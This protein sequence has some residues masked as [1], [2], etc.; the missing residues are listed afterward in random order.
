[1][2]AWPLFYLWALLYMS[3]LTTGVG[4]LRL[5]LAWELTVD[6]DKMDN[7]WNLV[8]MIS[9]HQRKPPNPEIGN[10][11]KYKHTAGDLGRKP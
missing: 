4:M 1:M 2:L 5:D 11:W 8:Y 3:H 6:F 10:V 9:R 7:R